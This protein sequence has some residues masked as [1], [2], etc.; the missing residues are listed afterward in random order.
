MQKP[1]LTE[2]SSAAKHFRAAACVIQGTASLL[3][4]WNA[5]KRSLHTNLFIETCR[6]PGPL[7]GL[8]DFRKE[9]IRMA[10]GANPLI[11]D[12]RQRDQLSLLGVRRSDFESYLAVTWNDLPVI[13]PSADDLLHT[14]RHTSKTSGSCLRFCTPLVRG[15]CP[16]L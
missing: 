14:S 6:C 4:L 10:L 15:F 7:G 11:F 9:K 16:G 8:K 3:D 1:V 13:V 2:I 5:N 12:Q